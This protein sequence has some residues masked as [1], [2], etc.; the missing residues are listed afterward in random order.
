MILSKKS[1]AII[2]VRTAYQESDLNDEMIDSLS[3]KF[4]TSNSFAKDVKE[5]LGYSLFEARRGM[6]AII[7]P[8]I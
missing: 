8:N 4:A 7:N 5:L 6:Y 3:V 1:I 2:L